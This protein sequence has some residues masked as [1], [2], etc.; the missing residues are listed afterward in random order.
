MN[1]ELQGEVYKNR[2]SIIQTQSQTNLS[3]TLTK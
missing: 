3:V 2:F 1:Y